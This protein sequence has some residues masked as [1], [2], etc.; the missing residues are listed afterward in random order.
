M[1]KAIHAVVMKEA[2]VP[3]EEAEPPSSALLEEGNTSAP[4]L[5]FPELIQFPNS[6]PDK[7]F[8]KIG[9]RSLQ[10]Q[11]KYFPAGHHGRLEQLGMAAAQQHHQLAGAAEGPAAVRR[12]SPGH[13]GRE[14]QPAA[15]H[16]PV[17]RQPARS[18]EPHA[19]PAPQR[20]AGDRRAPDLLRRGR[21]PA[22]RGYATAACP[23]WCTAIPT[24]CCSWSPASARPIAATAPARAWWATRTSAIS[25]ASNGT[26]PCP[27]SS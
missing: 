19:A 23:A 18:A 14:R 3:S 5:L 6:K 8:L 22:G 16:H 1:K 15:A 13:D 21:R 11:R 9:P 25:T 7:T 20:R 26:G 4:S 24:A 2:E 10:F 27:T 17:L 12:R